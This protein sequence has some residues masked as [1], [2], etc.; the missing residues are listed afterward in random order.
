MMTKHSQ[1][2]VVVL[3]SGVTI[4]VS[5]RLYNV[6]TDAF[7]VGVGGA[8][9]FVE[10][11]N[12]G[13]PTATNNPTAPI[14]LIQVRD[15]AQDPAT[16]YSRPLEESQWI[17]PQCF[18][19]IKIG[20]TNAELATNSLLLAGNAAPAV[21]AYPTVVA[22][23]AASASNQVTPDDEFTYRIQISAHGDRTDWYNS[24]YNTPTA[25]GTFTTAADFTTTYPA[26]A[27]QRDFIYESIAY[28]FNGNNGNIAVVFCLELVASISNGSISL[29]DLA[30][31]AVFTLS[32]FIIGYTLDGKAVTMGMDNDVR[33]AINQLDL[34]L[35]TGLYALR[36][37]VMPGTPTITAAAPYTVGVV[38]VAGTGPVVTNFCA[39]A[40]DEGQAV[41]DYKIN[42]KRRITLGLV[43]GFDNV[44][45]AISTE[46]KE[47]TGTG[48]QLSIMYK[49]N[50]AYNQAA[51]PQ[52]YMSYYVQFPNE[53][54]VD[55]YYDLFYVEHCHQ[56]LA[57]S[58]MPA[59]M[60]HTTVIAVLNTTLGGSTA[61]NP[62]YTGVA[63]PQRAV[64]VTTLNNFDSNFNLG[65]PNLV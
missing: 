23:P 1:M 41:Y 46:A 2:K 45:Q 63:N 11:V 42:T 19:G 58:G 8:A 4:P 43:K 25:F 48:R 31:P 56:R 20:V 39:L 51:R 7:N 36:P 12:S 55:G 49:A 54:K 22:I 32:K 15:T 27:N 29:A 28:N 9:F 3:R 59:I 16:L 57:T 40:I 26:V 6:S 65:N 18:L 38:P 33:E 34:A 47:G 17:S 30:D 52:P 62:Y 24:V 35:G 37:Y 61:V 21:A 13:N 50:E 10:T 44:D 14:K 64:C 60:P 53:V 5:G